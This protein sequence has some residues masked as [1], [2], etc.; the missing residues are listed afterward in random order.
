MNEAGSTPYNYST[1]TTD[2]VDPS[3]AYTEPYTHANG[4]QVRAGHFIY[5]EF[6][7]N[8]L[9]LSGVLEGTTTQVPE[10][11]VDPGG[12][13]GFVYRE[14]T[15]DYD[16]P[17]NNTSV[18]SYKSLDGSGQTVVNSANIWSY[19]N[20]NGKS[21]KLPGNQHVKLEFFISNTVNVKKETILTTYKEPGT[22]TIKQGWVV[23]DMPFQDAFIKITAEQLQTRRF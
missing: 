18:I 2:L 12:S 8:R 13:Y 22:G 7:P 3:Q 6:R 10:V 5:Q 1:F 15:K 20:L 17:V 4:S 23:V 19:P 21:V 16:L 11:Y 9:V 14:A